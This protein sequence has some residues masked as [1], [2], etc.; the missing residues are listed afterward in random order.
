MSDP[1]PI[2]EITGERPTNYSK[3]HRRAL[4]RWCYMTDGDW[5]EQRVIDGKLVSV[6]YVETIE[7][8]EV[9]SADINYPLWESKKALNE[10]IE[11]KMKIPALIVY[12]NPECNDFL[13]LYGLKKIRMDTTQYKRFIES[14]GKT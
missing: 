10:E 4:P 5:F 3:W 12:H 2:E 1:S 14:L 11:G 7:V 9:E 6:A 8:D 13:V